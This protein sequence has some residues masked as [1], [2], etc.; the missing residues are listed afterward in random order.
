MRQTSTQ[1][2]TVSPVPAK[3]SEVERVEAACKAAIEEFDRR[4]EQLIQL[5]ESNKEAIIR[6][7]VRRNAP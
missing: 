7:K 1:V 6:L 4:S 5:I 2:P 3:P